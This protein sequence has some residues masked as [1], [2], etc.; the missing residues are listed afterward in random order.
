MALRGTCPR[1]HEEDCGGDA[2]EDDPEEHEQYERGAEAEDGEEIFS[3]DV[4]DAEGSAGPVEADHAGGG[5]DA[6]A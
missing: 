2:G 1:E 3:H 5:G 6:L 4:D